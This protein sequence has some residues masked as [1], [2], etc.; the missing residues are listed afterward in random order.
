[1]LVGDVQYML[2]SKIVKKDQKHSSCFLMFFSNQICKWS[3]W[4]IFQLFIHVF[5]LSDY[6]KMTSSKIQLFFMFFS[7]SKVFL[8]IL[9]CN[10]FIFFLM[11]PQ[12]HFPVSLFFCNIPLINKSKFANVIIIIIQKVTLF[13][14]QNKQHKHLWVLAQNITKS[15]RS[16]AISCYKET[17]SQFLIC[18]TLALHFHHVHFVAKV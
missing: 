3:F 12:Y 14:W 6:L 7:N 8:I 13:R 11:C 4:E 17:N 18:K 16:F 9:F 15:I 1:M 10:Q 2:M 5:L